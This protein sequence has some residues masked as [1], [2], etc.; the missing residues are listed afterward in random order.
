MVGGDVVV[1][2]NITINITITHTITIAI[3][4][5][6]S[7]SI[8]ITLIIIFIIILT[9]III[10]I[11][12]ITVTPAP[13]LSPPPTPY[14]MKPALSKPGHH[15]DF[16]HDQRILNVIVI[17]SVFVMITSSSVFPSSSSPLLLT[18][19]LSTQTVAISAA[20]NICSNTA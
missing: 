12:N 13:C 15:L 7:I 8:I 2:V 20:T 17:V 14:E 1:E 3:T 9:H 10:A 5:V 11:V 4:I 18:Y 6:A 16:K 19:L